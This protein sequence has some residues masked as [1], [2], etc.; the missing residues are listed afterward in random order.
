RKAGE[1]DAYLPDSRR[2][3]GDPE[4]RSPHSRDARLLGRRGRGRPPG[5]GPRRGEPPGRDPARL[6]HAGDERHGVPARAPPE[7]LCRPAQGG[8]LH[9]RER[10]RPYP[11]RDCRRRRRICNE[12]VRPRHAP[13]QAADRRRRVSSPTAI[14]RRRLDGPAAPPIRLMIADD[15]EV[16][17]AVLSRMVA[18]HDEFEIIATA[19]NAGE[20][21]DALKTVSVDIIILDV[22]MPGASG[23]EALP[24]IVRAGRG[25]RVLIV[26]SMAEHGAE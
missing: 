16:A 7:R 12:T 25:A 4:G 13:F 24:D 5:A 23:L 15:S 26:S 21:L 11:G 22:E 6:E 1:N 10:H 17:R 14:A 2:Q 3:Q 18:V 20:A 19:G 8:V 9:Y